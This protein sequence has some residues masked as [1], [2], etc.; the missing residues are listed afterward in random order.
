MTGFTTNAMAAP[1][2]PATHASTSVHPDDGFL[3]ECGPP[4]SEPS[5]SINTGTA[6]S[7]SVKQAQ[8]YLNNALFFTSVPFLTVD[9]DFG[10][11]TRAATIDFQRCW[12]HLFN[13]NISVDGGIG[14]QTWPRLQ[15]MANGETSSLCTDA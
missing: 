8:C 14:P 4:T 3:I 1:K 9:G 15:S 13:P 2:A 12:N 10:S 7:D 11:H 5:I 6:H